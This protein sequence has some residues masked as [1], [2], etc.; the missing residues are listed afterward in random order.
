MAE[1]QVLC[2]VTEFVTGPVKGSKWVQTA[3]HKI[4]NILGSI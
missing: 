4:F 3:H 2:K 1:Q